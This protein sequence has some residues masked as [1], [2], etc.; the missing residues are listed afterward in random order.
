M[1][2]F[3]GTL[4][5]SASLWVSSNIIRGSAFLTAL[6]WDID[7]PVLAPTFVILQIMSIGNVLGVGFEKVYLMQNPANIMVSEV[8]STYTYTLGIKG[9]EALP[10][11]IPRAMYT[12]VEPISGL[13]T[14]LRRRLPI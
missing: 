5:C 1:R 14:P 3:F 4:P 2:Q 10:Y 8:I 12:S 7:L 9:G 11:S 13:G 6:G